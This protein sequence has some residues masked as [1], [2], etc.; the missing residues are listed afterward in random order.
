MGLQPVRQRAGDGIRPGQP[1][2]STARTRGLPTWRGRSTT[3]PENGFAGDSADG[4]GPAARGLACCRGP[5]ALGAG[6]H[7]DGVRSRLRFRSR[8]PGARRRLAIH[9]CRQR[10]RG[11]LMLVENA[12][13]AGAGA[14]KV[15]RRRGHPPLGYV[16]P[17]R[18]SGSRWPQ[19]HRHHRPS[20]ESAAGS[21]CAGGWQTRCGSAPSSP[22]AIYQAAADWL[23][24]PL[25][26]LSPGGSPRGITS[27]SGTTADCLTSTVRWR[28]DLSVVTEDPPKDRKAALTSAHPGSRPDLFMTYPSEN[29][30]R[31]GSQSGL[32][33]GPPGLL[34]Y[35]YRLSDLRFY[36][37]RVTGIEPAW[38]AWKARRAR[39]GR[40]H[41]PL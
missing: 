13:T 9:S 36:V 10:P 5:R 26:V 1:A 7:R 32:S 31:E 37:E 39:N 11:P 24:V 25:E 2:A 14:A 29:R 6:G 8:C 27:T 18:K 38:P 16:M 40:H 4:P 41:R 19:R 21:R 17:P 3:W 34:Q 23:G 35:A 20:L 28:R 30:G 33:E 12:G 15:V 22:V